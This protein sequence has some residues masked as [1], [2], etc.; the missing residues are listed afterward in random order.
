MCGITGIFAFN[1]IGRMQLIHLENATQALS[2]RGPDHHQTYLDQLVGLGHRRLSILDTSH[3]AHQPMSDQSER[4]TLVFNG[5]IYNYKALRKELSQKGYT[6]N[7]DGDTEV[8]LNLLIDQGKE[9]INK[10]NGFFAFAFFD[11]KENKLLI[12][13]DRLGIKPL[14]VYQDADKFLFASEMKSML[15]YTVKREINKEALNYYLQ[16]NYTPAPLTMI[17]GVYKLLPGELMEVSAGG[18][19]I[20]SAYYQIP[21]PVSDQA[22]V[23]LSYDQAKTKLISLLETSVA[24]RMVSDVPLGAFLS[25]GIDSSVIT[26]LASRQNDQLKTFSIG[27]KDDKFFDETHYAKAVA[28]KFNT[29]H[30]VFSL[31]RNELL[32][33]VDDAVAYLDDPFADSSALPVFIL[34]K[35]TREHVTVSLSGDGADEIFSGYNKHA[36]WQKAASGGMLN[37]LVKMGGPLFQLMPKSRSGKLGNLFRQL[38]RFSKMLKLSPAERYW[39]LATFQQHEA[40]TQLLTA[41]YNQWNS[42]IK[43]EYLSNL[44][45]KSFNHFLLT[46]SKL[47][48]PNDMLTKVDLMS[49]ANHLEVRVP[50]LDHRVVEF[51]NSL[52]AAYKIDGG[53]RK[54]VLQEAFREILPDELYNRP[55]K[56][57]EVPLLSWFNNELKYTLEKEVFNRDLLESQGIFQWDTIAAMQKKLTSFDPGDVHA[58]IWAVFVFQRW[59]E[60]YIEQ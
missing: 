1:E 21:K 15:T 20:K 59:Y 30:T 41:D 56:G 25:G 49:M 23:D 17:E 37:S 58:K 46:D 60:K 6:F 48:L 8:L 26:A 42:Q 45:E 22:T 55:K 44:D 33:H 5:E 54:R 18:K 24:D 43:D 27:Y 4:Y 31:S 50:F 35:K 3:A 29:D 57:F 39:F 52:P 12:A 2:R 19:S 53:I 32:E 14:L 36:A 11:K 38:L 51:A 13:R 28:E 16:L 47:V 10:L 34:S 7:S 9:A 40:V